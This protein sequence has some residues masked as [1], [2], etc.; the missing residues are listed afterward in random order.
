MSAHGTTERS[1]PA[2]PTR[3]DGPAPGAVA[4]FSARFETFR[5]LRHRNFRLYFSGQLISL[6]GSW[7]QT[8]ALTWLA[9]GLTHANRWSALVAAAQLLPTFFLGP[10]TGAL[11]DRW[12]RR[13]I[14]LVTQALLLALAVALGG[15][16]LT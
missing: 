14:L 15:L 4:R 6:T 16:V 13:S 7:V 8:T 3:P 9:Y 5:S 11:A 10:W 2:P 1:P 12:P